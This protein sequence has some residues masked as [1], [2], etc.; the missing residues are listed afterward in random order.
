MWFP[1][2]ESTMMVGLSFLAYYFVIIICC[3]SFSHKNSTVNVGS[4][5]LV[6]NR[7]ITNWNGTL[8]VTGTV[9]GQPITFSYGTLEKN[10]VPVVLNAQYT[11]NDVR[12]QIKLNSN[13]LMRADPGQLARRLLLYVLVIVSRGN[14][15]LPL[16][17]QLN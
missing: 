15:F 13:Q 2:A 4:S 7:P 3:F 10:N 1:R 17:I 14:R 9:T 6:I 5:K 11:P 16:L 12:Q 8:S